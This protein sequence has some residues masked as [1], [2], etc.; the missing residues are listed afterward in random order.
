MSVKLSIEEEKNNEA[1]LLEENKDE[2]ETVAQFSRRMEAYFENAS[3]ANV[4]RK[5]QEGLHSEN[6]KMKVEIK[7]LREV[8]SHNKEELEKMEEELQ[9]IYDISMPELVRQIGYSEGDENHL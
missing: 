3:S 1:S 6:E 4:N 7:R 8:I 5:S 9:N 2:Y